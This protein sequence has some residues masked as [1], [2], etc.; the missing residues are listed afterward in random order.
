MKI[1]DDYISFANGKQIYV[2]ANIIG[3]CS[4]DGNLYISYG[5][6]GTIDEGPLT[7]EERIELA[8]YMI[9]LWAKL[10]EDL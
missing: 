6:D 1:E 4:E 3:I 10:K 9:A 5:A 8:D 2:H 7:K